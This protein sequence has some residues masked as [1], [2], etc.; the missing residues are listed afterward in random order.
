MP[1]FTQAVKDFEAA[2]PNIKVDVKNKGQTKDFAP[3]LAQ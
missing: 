3:K 1:G 2:N